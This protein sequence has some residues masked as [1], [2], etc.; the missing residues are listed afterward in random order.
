MGPVA[1]RRRRSASVPSGCGRRIRCCCPWP[2]PSLLSVRRDAIQNAPTRRE[3]NHSLRTAPGQRRACN[4]PSTASARSDTVTA[5]S[6]GRARE[7]IAAA[8][9]AALPRAQPPA[10]RASSATSAWPG[11]SPATS[12]PAA[13]RQRR[14]PPLPADRL[15]ARAPGQN[16]RARHREQRRYTETAPEE[17]RRRRRHPLPAIGT[18]EAKATG[19]AAQ[20]RRQTARLAR[21]GRA[22]QLTAAMRAPGRAAGLRRGRVDQLEEGPHAG[23]GKDGVNEKTVRH[24]DCLWRLHRHHE[25]S[26]P[27]NFFARSRGG[28]THP[29]R[30][31]NVSGSAPDPLRKSAHSHQRLAL[32]ASHFLRRSFFALASRLLVASVPALAIRRA[33][34]ASFRRAV[35]RP[36]SAPGRGSC[37]GHSASFLPR[38]EARCSGSRRGCSPTP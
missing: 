10:R 2:H 13:Q 33:L 29:Q 23:V 25:T 12:P 5:A 7:C 6:A 14:D 27:A 30:S 38:V 37:A 31:P 20:R 11:S 15:Q 8:R 4:P 3:K 18:A 34:R 26:P 17:T 32:R 36:A 35:Q 16:H 24:W 22:V 28:G 21:V 9:R 19:I 1:A